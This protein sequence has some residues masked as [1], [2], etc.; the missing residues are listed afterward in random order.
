[1]KRNVV[2]MKLKNLNDIQL[3]LQCST[4]CAILILP[5]TTCNVTVKYYL[6][7]FKSATNWKCLEKASNLKL[8]QRLGNGKTTRK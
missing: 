5:S 6:E 2:K 7:V 4:G 3:F 8:S 1:M